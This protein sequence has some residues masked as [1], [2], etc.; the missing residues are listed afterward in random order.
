[1]AMSFRVPSDNASHVRVN[2]K[3]ASR[4]IVGERGRAGETL[5]GAPVTS[6]DLGFS[7]AA[8]LSVHERE[9]WIGC[10]QCRAKLP[11]K[12]PNR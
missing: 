12:V 9:Q 10:E 3:T 8:R 2:V 11:A 1:M 7:D 4:R 6:F 5:C